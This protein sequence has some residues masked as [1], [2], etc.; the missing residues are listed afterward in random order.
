[1]LKNALLFAVAALVLAFSA[2]SLFPERADPGGAPSA[3]APAAPAKAATN[4]A[5]NGGLGLREASIPADAGGQFHANASIE[6]QDVDVLIDTGASMVALTADTAARL[7]VAVDPSAP[8]VQANTANGVSLVSPVVLRQV[9]LGSI[10]M[11]DVEA[12]VMPPGTGTANLLG[13]SFLKR[14]ASVEQRD[15]VLV[16]KQ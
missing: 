9:R 11:N 5:A 12:V 7:G 3:S 14:L 10:D 2:P 16:L 13:A 6:G 15:G 1:M 8:K 4:A